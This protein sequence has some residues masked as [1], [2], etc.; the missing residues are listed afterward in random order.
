MLLPRRAVLM[1]AMLLPDPTRTCL[2]CPPGGTCELGYSPLC[3]YSP[4]TRTLPYDP[5]RLLR[6]QFAMLLQAPYAPTKP[7]TRT[8]PYAPTILLRGHSHMILPACYA[9]K[10]LCS[11]QPPTRTVSYAPR[12]CY[13]YC[14]LCPTSLLRGELPTGCLLS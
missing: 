12:G 1:V 7:A 8:L 14:S 10:S 6:V 3:S 9:N 4:P 2:P 13:A 11:Y 5:T